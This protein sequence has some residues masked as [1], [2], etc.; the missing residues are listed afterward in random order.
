MTWIIKV[1]GQEISSDDFTLDE[2]GQIEKLADTSWSIANPLRHAPVAK[3][4]LRVAIAKSGGNPQ[5]ADTLTLRE[6]KKVFSY[7][8][9]DEDEETEGSGEEPDPLPVTSPGS[10]PGGPSATTGPRKKHAA[11]AS[12]TS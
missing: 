7:R 12:A 4:F 5:D 8:P 9:D 10:S 11:N 2:L 1:G 6:V 3:A